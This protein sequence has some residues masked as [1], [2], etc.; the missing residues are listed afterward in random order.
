MPI[1]LGRLDSSLQGVG[2]S[3]GPVIRCYQRDAGRH[4]VGEINGA[5][6]D[7]E[8]VE[9]GV[10]GSGNGVAHDWLTAEGRKQL[11][12]RPL[13]T[14]SGPAGENDPS[15]SHLVRLIS[16]APCQTASRATRQLRAKRPAE[17]QDSSVP[18]GQQSGDLAGVDHAAGGQQI[19]H[20]MLVHQL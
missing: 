11:V 2:L 3:I 17:R 14:R 15:N 1:G 19:R 18:N 10:V 16:P 7:I 9:S 4:D 20:R 12:R 5:L 13:E 6:H 8:L